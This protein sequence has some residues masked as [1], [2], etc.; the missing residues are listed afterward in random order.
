MQQS[1]KGYFFLAIV[2]A[3]SVLSGFLFTQKQYQFGLDIKGGVRL[4]YKIKELTEDQKKNLPTIMSNLK[5]VMTERASKNLGVVEGNVVQKGEQELII[6]LPNFTDVDQ[7]RETISSTASIKLY[8]AKTVQTPQAGWRR[9][10]A[11]NTSNDDAN[12][13]EEFGDKNDPTGAPF[14][15]KDPRYNEM[16]K[17]W[18]LILEGSDLAK[19]EVIVEGTNF[20][21]QFRFSGEGAK[22]LETW[23]NRFFGREEK[24]AFVLDGKVLNIA[25]VEPTARLGDQ[26]VLTGTFTAQYSNNLVNLLNA[27]ALPVELEETSSQVVDPTIGEFALKNMV[28]AGTIAFVVIALFLIIYYSFPG[29]VALVALGLYVLFT[30]VAMK[31]IGATFSLAAIAGFILSVGMAVDA[32]ILVFER[33]KEEMRQGRALLTSVELGFKRAF[34]AILDSNACTILTSLVLVYL[35]Q[36]AVKGFATTLIIG[37]AISL[38]TA[39]VV[40]RSLLVFFVSSGI[41]K[42]E[43]LFAAERGWFGE[44]WEAKADTEQIQ[45]VNKARKYFIISAATVIVC[46]PFFFMGGLKPNVEFLGG[47]EA[48]YKLKP[49]ATA[50]QA[51]ANLEAA[52]YKGVNGKGFRGSN[53]EQTLSLTVPQVPGLKANDP[54]AYDV[55]AEKAKVVDKLAVTS[56]Q[57]VG[58]S[59]QQETIRNAIIAIIVS[60]A[61]IVCYLAF[62]FG[63]ALGSFKN[64]LKFG[65]SAIL[66][67]VHDI[68]VVLGIAAACG[69]AFGWE[70]SSLFMT[71]MLTVI[72]FSV[73]DTIVIFDR[74]R[75]NLSKP[76]A[77]EDFARLCNK[78]ITQ[79]FA[80]SLN[81]SMTVIATLIILIAMG[82]P[83]IDLKFFCVVMLAGILSGTYSSIFNA[84]PILYLW[85]KTVMKNRGVEAGLI[86]EAHAE[87]DRKRHLLRQAEAN[88]RMMTGTAGNVAGG[89]AAKGYGAVKRRDSAVDRSKRNIDEEE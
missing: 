24:I 62:R 42:S 57:S 22:K 3:L 61:L 82:T 12:P 38:F 67:L 15:F 55:I 70:L 52:G 14:G 20:Q 8:H 69:W 5:R 47:F 85:D 73:H 2:L 65:M 44:K 39:V 36:G 26:A 1:K 4:T 27:G 32:N 64:G 60:S 76:G 87:N 45:I 50:A 58:P 28:S 25:G 23:S 80:R 53:G 86:A 74:I 63:L 17:G 9:F 48:N 59:I 34:P 66:A 29:F 79:S 11:A 83:T 78:S 89:Q 40:T 16:I 19:A 46:L 54:K 41:V 6:E 31:Y 13:S 75:E 30:L 51:V 56:I 35:G 10:S 49:G 21:P 84:A 72:G 43:K 7:A 33:V 77:N 88:Q 18:D 37:V 81:T 71:S 68:L